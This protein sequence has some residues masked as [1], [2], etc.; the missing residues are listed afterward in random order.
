MTK[1]DLEEIVR[2][3][4]DLDEVTLQEDMKIL[5][6]ENWTSFNHIEMMIAVEEASSVTLT[7]EEIQSIETFGALSKAVVEKG[8]DFSWE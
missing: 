3:I 8:G 4:F 6:V 7:T 1:A 5:T 2:D